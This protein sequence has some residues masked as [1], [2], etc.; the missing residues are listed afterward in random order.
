MLLSY[1]VNIYVLATLEE[2]M[3]FNLQ[4]EPWFRALREARAQAKKG[5]NS[6]TE[7]RTYAVE[8]TIYHQFKCMVD[9]HPITIQ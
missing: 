5:T 9:K 8:F 4:L 2:P 6:E 3:F 1:I 7:L